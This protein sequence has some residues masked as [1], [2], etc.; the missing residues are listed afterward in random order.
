M[1]FT[2]WYMKY[3]NGNG[4]VSAL[5][6]DHAGVM[7]WKVIGSVCD[8]WVVIITGNWRPESPM[9]D[10]YQMFRMS[11]DSIGSLLDRVGH[12]YLGCQ[13]VQIV[14]IC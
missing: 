9:L 8:L 2:A 3:G 5:S 14:D 6:A 12:N 4:I 11:S 13:N 1:K 10:I 7:R